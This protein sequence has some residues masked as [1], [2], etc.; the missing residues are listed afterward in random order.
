[1]RESLSAGALCTRIVEVVFPD[2]SL[3]AAARLMRERHVGCLVV[4]NS[5]DPGRRVAGLITDRDIVVSAVAQSRDPA[6]VTVGAI[7]CPDVA[8]VREDDD[9]P[10]VLGLMRRRGVRRLPV[11][12]AHGE[13]L[14]LLSMDDLLAALALQVQAMAEAVVAGRQVEGA[15][16]P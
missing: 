3:T 16:R 5:E 12:S 6:H 10:T 4:V 9:L 7:M 13:L 2:L 1:M 14:G 11:V 8:M 15:A